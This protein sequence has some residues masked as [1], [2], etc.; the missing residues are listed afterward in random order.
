MNK[1]VK[2]NLRLAG[3]KSK[4]LKILEEFFPKE[5]D[6]Y[7]IFTLEEFLEKETPAE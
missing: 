4:M 3:G 7:K 5:I 6:K 1:E 2:T